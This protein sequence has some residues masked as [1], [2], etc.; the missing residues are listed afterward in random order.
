[1]LFSLAELL[2]VLPEKHRLRPGLLV[3]FR[4]LSEGVLACQ[5][6]AGMWHQ[7]LTDHESY[8][9]TSC[10]AMFTYAFSCGVRHG[11][12]GEPAKYIKAA[13]KG[14]LGISKLSVDREGNVYGV[15]IGSGFSFQAEYYKNDL[16]WR[17]ND[18]HGIGIV[19]LAGVEIMRLENFLKPNH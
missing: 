19:L 9:E 15:C 16:P 11:W 13:K 4:E 14:W 10:T 1:V 7:V 8:I 3:F 2:M 6:G 18:T 17:T 5:D 12:Y